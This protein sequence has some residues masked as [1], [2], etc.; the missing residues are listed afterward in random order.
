VR[1]GHVEFSLAPFC[2]AVKINSRCERRLQDMCRSPGSGPRSEHRLHVH[3]AYHVH[4]Q[5]TLFISYIRPK[6][7]AHKPNTFRS[8]FR[9]PSVR[10]RIRKR[11]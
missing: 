1:D 9:P 6:S 8:L 2:S 3:T 4:S 10:P 11:Q 5:R 7:M